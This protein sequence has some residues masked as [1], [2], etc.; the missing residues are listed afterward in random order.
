MQ[1]IVQTMEYA[2]I[3]NATVKLVILARIVLK[4]IVTQNAKEIVY[5]IIKRDSVNAKTIISLVLTVHY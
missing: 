2:R 5:V 1:R 3:R 4:R